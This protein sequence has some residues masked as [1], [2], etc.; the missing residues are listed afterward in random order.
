[1]RALHLGS[2]LLLLAAPAGA[3]TIN[4]AHAI[5]V[6]GGVRSGE[7][8][9]APMAPPAPGASVLPGQLEV[10]AHVTAVFALK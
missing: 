7:Y 6:D 1:M 10:S 5:T 8:A 9:A 3:D 2:A 4:L